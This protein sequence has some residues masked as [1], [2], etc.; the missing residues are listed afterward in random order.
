MTTTTPPRQHRPPDYHRDHA[1]PRTAPAPTSDAME[2]RL[3]ELISPATYRLRDEYRRLGLR[4]RVLSLPVMVALLLAMIW[5][6]IPSVGTLLQTLARERLLWVPP[7]QVSQQA[8][9]DRFDVLP[10]QLV[11]QT[12]MTVLPT[13]AERAALR[14]RPLPPAVAAALH[15]FSHLWALDATVLEE[16]FHKVGL[17]R[18]KTGESIPGG[19]LFG[20]LDIATK[21]PAALWYD[22]AMPHDQAVLPALMDRIPRG[23]LLLFD[24]G[25]HAFAFFDWLTEH[26]CCFITLAKSTTAATVVTTLV[27]TPRVRDRIVRLGTYRSSPCH[28]EM[29]LI[30]VAVGG[31]WYRYLTNVTDPA[32]LGAAQIVDLYARRWRIEEAFSLVKRLLGLAY[33]WTGT[34]NG[35]QLQVWATWL[36]YAVLV[37]LSDAVAEE[38]DVPLDRIS[39]EMVFRGLY[40]FSVAYHRGEA[41]DPVRY[42]ATQDDLGIVKRRRKS[43]EHQRLLDFPPELIL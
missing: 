36:L 30:E 34:A 35:I 29:R 24:R 32:V 26:G 19:K 37:D 1:R 20:V 5:R 42:L 16:L 3:T 28:S 6:Q 43:R 13:L 27:E 14:R 40:H 18:E 17:L 22:E 31:R 7:F 4:E 41:D 33:L 2:Q 25:I 23:T 15:H 38:L 12:L 21:L 9:H 11:H 10:A 39:L 8:I